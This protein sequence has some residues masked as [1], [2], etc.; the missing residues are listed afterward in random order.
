MRVALVHDWVTVPGGSEEVLKEEMSLYPGVLYAAMCDQARYRWLD[1]ME[2]RTSWLQ[3]MP[4]AK[5][6]HYLYSPLLTYIYPKFDLEDFDLVLSDSHSFAHGVIKRPGALHINYYHSPARALWSPEIDNRAQGFFRSRIANVLRKRD[7]EFSKRP[8]V[9]FANSRTTAERVERF[10][11]RKVQ[12]VI[13][14][15]VHTARFLSIPRKSEEEGYLIWGRFIAYK[16][17]DL[18]IDA[19]KRLG[20]KLNIVG[21]GPLERELMARAGGAKNIA[22]PGRLSDEDLSQLISRSKA[23]LFPCYED[24][25]IIPVEAMAAGLPVIA[26]AKGGAGETVTPEQGLLMR[27]LTVDE[28]VRA[29]GELETR[30]FDEKAIR[31]HAKQFDVEVFRSAYKSE[32]DAAIE[33]HRAH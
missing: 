3:K 26:Y 32:V 23:V 11:G 10:Y 24:F 30:T 20:F 4:F 6:K 2:V 31:E 15:P 29:V 18:A 1:G 25:G 5:T 12:R 16:R 17:F 8:D 9:I 13:Y 7:L 27:D 33:R 19:A 28:L 21:S 22:F 14:P